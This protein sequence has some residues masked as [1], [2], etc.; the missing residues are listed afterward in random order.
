MIIQVF[1]F[2]NTSTEET[3]KLYQECLEIF[4]GAARSMVSQVSVQK[5]NVIL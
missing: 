3:V 1:T 5:P 4:S 2:P